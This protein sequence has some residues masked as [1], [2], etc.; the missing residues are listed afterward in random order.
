[1]P[2]IKLHFKNRQTNGYEVKELDSDDISEY[3][4]NN[5]GFGGW[6]VI[7]DNEHEVL[8][9][10][11]EIERQ[12]RDNFTSALERSSEVV[13]QWPEWKQELLGGKATSKMN[14]QHEKQVREYDEAITMMLRTIPDTLYNFYKKLQDNGFNE[15]QA[16]TLTRDYLNATMGQTPER[17]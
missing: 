6:V 5:S 15:Q 11:V 13:S 12:M 16:F 3:G 17:E 10:E 7:G 1:M 8:E 14:S 9:N 2:T 4:D